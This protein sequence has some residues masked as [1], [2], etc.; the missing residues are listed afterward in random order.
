MTD[1]KG[2]DGPIRSQPTLEELG[3]LPEQ[4]KE[5]TAMADLSP[6]LRI[7]SGATGSGK[8]TT[9]AA[10]VAIAQ[11]AS[12]SVVVLQEALESTFEGL[13]HIRVDASETCF[14][15]EGGPWEKALRQ[16]V[17]SAPD[18][19]VVG[20]LRTE[21]S[22]RAAF[23]MV[24]RGY[25]VWTTVHAA[26]ANDALQR[27]QS[28]GGSGIEDLIFSP[29]FVTGL[30]HLTRAPRLSGGHQIL[31]EVIRPDESYLSAYRIYGAEEARVRWM[32]GPNRL[33]YRD[34][35]VR[36]VQQGLLDPG[37]LDQHFGPS[38]S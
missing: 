11:Q 38:D 9:V 4:A 34:V 36:K 30:I 14:D 31:A 28:M 10:V 27:L 1:I 23:D 37:W 29:S 19:V 17:R 16:S 3:Y 22:V 33:T 35:G 8:S 6:G 5:I 13:P 21:E 26:M 18:L 24:G 32:Q 7:V 2:S 20:E 12:A 15:A 25:C